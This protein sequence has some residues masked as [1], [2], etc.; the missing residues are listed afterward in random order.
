MS[1]PLIELRMLQYSAGRKA[2]L[3]E[4]SLRLAPGETL[5][6]IGRTGAGKTTLLR[7]LL[8]LSFP[9]AGEALL[10]D[11]PARELSRRNKTRL[12]YVPQTP[13]L[14]E[15]HTLRTLLEWTESWQPGWDVRRGAELIERFEL[16]PAQRV[17]SLSVGQK[18]L[19][20]LIMAIGH[21]PE[22]L[23]LD[24]PVASLDPVTRRNVASVLAE[25]Q[26]E[27]GTSMVF[28]TH[29][30]SELE[31]LATHVAVMEEGRIALHCETDDIRTSLRRWQLRSREGQTL[32]HALPTS[33][34][35]PGL[36]R[37]RRIDARHAS[38]LVDTRAGA[39]LQRLPGQA[40]EHSLNL[41]DF[42]VEYLQ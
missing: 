11:A 42:V 1:S 26:A 30:L 7:C 18:Q 29:I 13:G 35:I 27:H 5:G 33:L 4:A 3:D 17:S 23:V 19:A 2:I 28:S 20:A 36:L 31:R 9:Q 16:D 10:F 25:L 39:D 41:E 37:Y 38:L 6:L 24:E 15:S 12:G 40:S 8:G 14:P 34:N 32:G 21:R 22:L